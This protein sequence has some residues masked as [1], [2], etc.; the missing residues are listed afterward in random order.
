MAKA[1]AQTSVGVLSNRADFGGGGDSGGCPT[2]STNQTNRAGT[3]MY[4]T[5]ESTQHT[6]TATPR[7][8]PL[9]PIT[10]FC[11]SPHGQGRWKTTAHFRSTCL[12]GM[13]RTLF[14]WRNLPSPGC[15]R[16]YSYGDYLAPLAVL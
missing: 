7:H 10:S 15:L 3:T 2:K 6:C 1:E 11:P 12:L 16:W 9:G 8:Q 4:C 14:L 13:S 5:K